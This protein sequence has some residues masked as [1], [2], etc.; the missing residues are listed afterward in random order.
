MEE[1][2]ENYWKNTQCWLQFQRTLGDAMTPSIIQTFSKVLPKREAK[3]IQE[4]EDYIF[5]Y[6]IKH[7]YFKR[8]DAT[9][10]LKVCEKHKELQSIAK[11]IKDYHKKLL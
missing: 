9:K 6:L 3:K 8:G 2:D 11:I 4:T 5:T 7:S 1:I 10:L